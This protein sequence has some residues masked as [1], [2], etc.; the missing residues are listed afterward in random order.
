MKRISVIVPHKTIIAAI[1]NTRYMFGLVN[2][3]L[4]NSGNP[5]LFDVKFVGAT[6]EIRLDDGLYTV[7]VDCA[8]DEVGETDLIIIPP[9]S[10]DMETA[11]L[12]NRE[13]VDWIRMQYE[14]GAEVASLCVG[15][16]ILA[17]TGL[18]NGQECSTHWKTVNEFRKKYPEV[19]LVDYRIIT[20]HNGLYTSGGANSYWNLL[21]YVVQKFTNR[22]IAIR[23]SKYFEVEIDRNNQAPFMIFEGYK[24]HPDEP[25]LDAQDYIEKHYKERITIAF[26]SEKFNMSRR[27]FQRRFKAATHETVIEYLQ[28]I[29]MEAAKKMLELNRLSIGE[30]MFEV[31]Y[32]DPTAFRDVFKKITGITP[33]VYKSKYELMIPVL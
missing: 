11:V 9:M 22:D 23:T 32:N 27:T 14:R 4:E 25:I 2:G 10:G 16:F 33:S 13:Y 29:R 19:E 30:V 1:G 7:N 28:K 20:D 18:L 24:L 26:L 6:P 17:E 12:E 31:G 5:P 15:A 3:F 8:L 21:V